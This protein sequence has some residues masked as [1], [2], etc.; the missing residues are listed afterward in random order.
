MTQA[1]SVAAGLAAI[2]AGMSAALGQ[3]YADGVASVPPIVGEVTAAQEALDIA[4]AVKAAVDPLNAS[5]AA[6][7]LD[8][9]KEDALLASVQSAAQALVALISPPAPV[10]PVP[11]P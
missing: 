10:P 8:K 2:Q 6:M 3:C 11:A 1:D 7:Q 5:I 4:A 9:Q